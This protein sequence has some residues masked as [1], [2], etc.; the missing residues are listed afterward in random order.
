M[1]VPKHLHTTVRWVQRSSNRAYTLAVLHN[2]VSL[3]GDRFS[4]M[5]M[6]S[7]QQRKWRSGA[8]LH[9]TRGI[10]T[11]SW[12][13]KTFHRPS[14]TISIR[15][16]MSS[17]QPIDNRNRD[18]AYSVSDGES[19]DEEAEEALLVAEKRGKLLRESEFYM[20]LSTL[21]EWVRQRVLYQ[22]LF[23]SC[24]RVYVVVTNNCLQL[25]SLG[26][27]SVSWVALA[28]RTPDLD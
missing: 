24:C 9:E 22:K 14:E 3:S 26:K 13:E 15:G 4:S 17:L 18:D 25:P 19:G 21:D 27:Y 10:P 28:S 8:W 16:G 6:T 23:H 7:S 5:F 1:H 2:S 20:C 12:S 11:E